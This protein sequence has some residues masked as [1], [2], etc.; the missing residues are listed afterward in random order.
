LTSAARGIASHVTRSSSCATTT[1]AASVQ[2][3]GA[4]CGSGTTTGS[5]GARLLLE[6]PARELG[7]V[8]HRGEAERRAD[9]VL[10]R[11]LDDAELGGDLLVRQAVGDEVGD[12]ALALAELPRRSRGVAAGHENRHAAIAMMTSRPMQASTTSRA[13]SRLIS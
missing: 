3:I 2:P 12:L 8:L 11:L 1:A 4:G 9:V 13:C 6:P 7:P 10:H 5:G